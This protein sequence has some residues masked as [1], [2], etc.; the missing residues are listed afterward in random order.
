[1]T[2]DGDVP[3]PRPG[4]P[5][6]RVDVLGVGVSAVSLSDAVDEIARWVSA[7]EQHYVCVTGVHG[8]MESQRDPELLRIHNGS[9]LTTP[10]GMPM[11]WAGHRAGARWMTRVYGP[12]LMLALCDRAVGEGWRS[13]FYGGKPGVP[14]LLQERL[15]ERVPGLEVVGCYSPPFRPLS[16]EEDADVVARINA[17]KPDLLWIGLSTPKQERWMA[18]HVGRIDVPVMLGVGAAFDIHAGVLPQ[19]PLWMQRHGLEWVYRLVREPRR[20]WRR[21]LRNNPAFAWAVLRRPPRLER[22]APPWPPI[23]DAGA[24]RSVQP[25]DGRMG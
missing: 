4:R 5:I 16:P 1:M 17:A 7:R 23:T 8:V 12:D 15:Q 2:A 6:P 9:G 24:P 3:G 11:V 22:P 14:E 18:A 21:Y 25:P 20:L 19:A 10:D 13:F